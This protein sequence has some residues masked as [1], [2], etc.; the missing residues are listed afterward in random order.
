MKKQ[1]SALKKAFPFV[2]G[3]NLDFEGGETSEN[4]NMIVQFSAAMHEIGYSQITFNV[5]RSK[6]WWIQILKTIEEKLPGF[7]TGFDLQTYDGGAGQDP[8]SWITELENQM[9]PYFDAANF[10]FP[11]FAVEGLDLGGALCPD[12]IQS[13]VSKWKKD[14]GINGGWIWRVEEIVLPDDPGAALCNMPSL[15]TIADYAKSMY[16]GLNG[17]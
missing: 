6:S 7:I 1:F 14:C 4:Q 17:K 8:C 15:P 11:G 3:F 5:F 2:V 16:D 10:V 9:G 13:K 12:E